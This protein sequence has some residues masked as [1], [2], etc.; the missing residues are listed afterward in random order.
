MTQH[1]NNRT[2]ENIKNYF[3][4]LDSDYSNFNNSNDICTPLECVK[5]MVDT[6]PSIFWN[7]EDIKVLDSCCGN[8]NFHSYI[9]MK[10]K[11]KNQTKAH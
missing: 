4:N 2:F 6:M 8:G 10:T 7:K 1:A 11:L 9:A 5:T 3:N